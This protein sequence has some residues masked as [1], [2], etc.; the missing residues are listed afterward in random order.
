MVYFVVVTLATGI[1]Y[2]KNNIYL[3]GFGDV[4][5]HSELGRLSVIILIIIVIIVIPKQTNELIRL[6]GMQSK[7]ARD[8][9]KSNLEVPHIII[10]GHVTVEALK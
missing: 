4:V 7:Y 2:K 1:N 6:M 9:Y 10:C 8:V 3:V 5:P